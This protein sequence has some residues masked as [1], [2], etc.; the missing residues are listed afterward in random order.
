MII[1]L[2][3]LS[4]IWTIVG[5]LIIMGAWNE[6]ETDYKQ[7]T[8]KVS[9]PLELNYE[10]HDTYTEQKVVMSKIY[11]EEDTIEYR[12]RGKLYNLNREGMES[13]EAGETLRLMIKKTSL[14]GGFEINTSSKS[15]PVS[16]IY[17]SN[18]EAI[19]PLE[20]GIA[21][22]KQRL[23]IGFGLLAMAWLVG[24]WA[25]QIK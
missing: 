8:G 4:I 9:R 5:I 15:A 14:L 21:H 12:L 13:I 3:A 1:F 18:G 11:L 23:L 16:G 19:I 2:Y 6:N 25:Y 24:I 17:R 10:I 7:I 20:K 22:A